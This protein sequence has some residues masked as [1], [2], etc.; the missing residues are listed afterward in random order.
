MSELKGFSRIY[1]SGDYEFVHKFDGTHVSMTCQ[2]KGCSWSEHTKLRKNSTN[3]LPPFLLQCIDNHV[4]QHEGQNKFKEESAAAV[5]AFEAAAYSGVAF[6]EVATFYATGAYGA[7]K[8]L[9]LR[10]TKYSSIV[11]PSGLRVQ[12][13]PE[14]DIEITNNHTFSGKLAVY[15]VVSNVVKVSFVPDK[16]ASVF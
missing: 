8:A 1:P 7:E 11:T 6:P 13:T 2:I 5:A 4:L 3:T 14:G 9:G 15:P 12:V 10:V 16:P